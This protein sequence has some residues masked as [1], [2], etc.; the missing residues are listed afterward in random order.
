MAKIQL[1]SINEK[2]D[3]NLIQVC[4]KAQNPYHKSGGEYKE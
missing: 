2:K 1:V 4:H 3:I